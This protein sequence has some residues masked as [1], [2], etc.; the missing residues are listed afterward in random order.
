VDVPWYRAVLCP[1]TVTEN[2][3][4]FK[5][6]TKFKDLRH[7]TRM[8]KRTTTLFERVLK[9]VLCPP[10]LFWRYGIEPVMYMAVYNVLSI[11]TELMA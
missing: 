4:L 1:W 11:L 3:F 10:G 5:V 9:L 6:G 8:K 7:G 2:A